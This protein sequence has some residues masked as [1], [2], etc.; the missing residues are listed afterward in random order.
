M[1]Y[2]TNAKAYRLYNVVNN[3]IITCMNKTF[4]KEI[5]WKWNENKELICYE[6]P[7]SLRD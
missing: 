4:D 6:G 7:R 3:T 1:G 2:Y 5:R